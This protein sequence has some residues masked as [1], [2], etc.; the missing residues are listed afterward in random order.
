MYWWEHSSKL[1]QYSSAK[2]HR[3]LSV[4]ARVEEPKAF[5]DFSI[6]LTELEGLRAEIIDGL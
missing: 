2:V 6:E 5:D 1:G 3:S 4:K